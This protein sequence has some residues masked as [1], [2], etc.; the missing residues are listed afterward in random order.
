MAA[1]RGARR[2][3]GA[4][5][6]VKV[7]SYFPRSLQTPEAGVSGPFVQGGTLPAPAV[8]PGPGGVLARRAVRV[9]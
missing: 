3:R 9:G 2:H 1:R 7:A 6:A 8:N 4:G 5:A